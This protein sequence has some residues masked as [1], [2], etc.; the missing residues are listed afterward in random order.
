MSAR[1]V[2]GVLSQN[3]L[4]LHWNGSKRLVVI[5]LDYLVRGVSALRHDCLSKVQLY[6]T[7]EQVVHK[8]YLVLYIAVGL[9]TPPE[10]KVFISVGLVI[11]LKLTFALLCLEFA[12]CKFVLKFLMF[13]SNEGLEEIANIAS[14]TDMRVVEDLPPFS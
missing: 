11:N 9:R 5:Y 7:W 6:L 3:L 4:L 1:F 2:E 13:V 10:L 14:N 8:I 12:R